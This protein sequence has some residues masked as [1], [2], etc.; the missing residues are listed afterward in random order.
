MGE[1]MAELSSSFLKDKIESVHLHTA[2]GLGYLFLVKSCFLLS[3]SKSLVHLTVSFVGTLTWA[4][5]TDSLTE[6]TPH[7]GPNLPFPHF[8][9]GGGKCHCG[10]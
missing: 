7:W 6:L 8:T 1:L 9:Y 10:T 4:S 3:F 5:Y 2:K